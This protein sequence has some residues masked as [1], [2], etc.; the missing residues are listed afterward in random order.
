MT[1]T[2]TRVSPDTAVNTG[3]LI[4]RLGIGAAILQAGLIKAADFGS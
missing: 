3:L 2:T 4:L 1:D